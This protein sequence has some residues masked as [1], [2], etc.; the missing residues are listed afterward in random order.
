MANGTALWITSAGLIGTAVAVR[1]RLR[2][3]GEITDDGVAG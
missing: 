2:K 1:A 3:V